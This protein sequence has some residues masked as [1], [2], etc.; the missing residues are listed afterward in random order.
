MEED[1]TNIEEINYLK[2]TKMIGHQGEV[3][4][5]VV[6]NYNAEKQITFF[7]VVSALAYIRIISKLY[8]RKSNFIEK[9]SLSSS[10]LSKVDKA[11]CIQH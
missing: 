11:K 3:I 8:L 7:V 1:T 9:Y 5:M 4:N 10:K 6:W 2:C